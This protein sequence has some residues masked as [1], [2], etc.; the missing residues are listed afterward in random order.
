[1]S[2]EE[3]LQ[4]DERINNALDYVADPN[5]KT[6]VQLRTA[7]AKLETAQD[8]IKF[9]DRMDEEDK[10][11]ASIMTDYKPL[12][13]TSYHKPDEVSLHNPEQAVDYVYNTLNGGLYSDEETIFENEFMEVMMMLPEEKDVFTSLYNAGKK[14]EAWAFYQALQPY[15]NQ[16]YHYMED[17]REN[18]NA[19]RYPVMMSTVSAAATVAQPLEYIA[20]LPGRLEALITGNENAQTDPYSEM[21]SLT[22]LKTNIRNQVSSDLEDWGWVYN[23]FM[24]SVDSWLN[25]AVARGIGL[26]KEM[27]QAGTLGL[28]YTQAFE[29]SL[30]NTM[31]QGNDPFGYDYVEAFV[32]AMIETATEILSV[33]N[34]LADPTNLLTYVTKIA[35]SE[36]SE[37][38]VGAIIEPYIKEMIGHKNQYHERAKQILADGYYI[39]AQGNKVEV[40]DMDKATRQ[41]MREWNHDIRMAAQEALVSV[42]PSIGVGAMRMTYNNSQL[43][44]AIN[45]NNVNNET[46]ATRNFAEAASKLK[47]KQSVKGAQKVLDQLEKKGKAKNTTVGQLAQDVLRESGEQLDE[48]T[49]ESRREQIKKDLMDAGVEE[50]EA[51]AFADSIEQA[52]EKGGLDKIGKKQRDAING[53]Q[54]AANTLIN[55]QQ[56]FKKTAE[57][58]DQAYGNEKD[59]VNARSV[60]MNLMANQNTKA[61]LY[62]GRNV[63]DTKEYSEA[64]GEE[65]KGNRGVIVYG[66]EGSKHAKLLRITN[67]TNEDGQHLYEVEV[68]GK[69]QLVTSDQIGTKNLGTAAI[70]E[71]QANNPRF[72]S[73][74]YVNKLLQEV[75]LNNKINPGVLM[76]DAMVIRL[77]AFT[78]QEMPK[79][80]LPAEVAQRMYDFSS[81][82]HRLNRENQTKLAKQNARKAGQGIARFKG[83]DI[84]TEEFDKAIE[85]LSEADKE[86]IRTYGALAVQAGFEV[87]FIDLDDIENSTDRDLSEFK[88][89]GNELYGSESRK[90]IKL[91]IA[92]SNFTMNPE[93]GR[94]IPVE[95]E[96]HHIGIAFGHE[97]VHWLQRNT[98]DGYDNLA[99]YVLAEQ[100]KVLGTAGL[101]QQIERY[102]RN[103][104]L[105][106]EDAISELVADSCDRIFNQKEVIDHIQQTNVKLYNQL[107]SFVKDLVQRAKKVIRGHEKSMSDAGRRMSEQAM[108]K[109]AELYNIAWDEATGRKT[110]SGTN[111]RKSKFNIDNIKNEEYNENNEEKEGINDEERRK[112]S[113]ERI[114]EQ[115][116]ELLGLGRNW[117]LS[118]KEALR[119]LKGNNQGII[120]PGQK[121]Y[122]LFRQALI[123]SVFVDRK[124][125]PLIWL[126][127]TDQQ[128]SVFDI[129]ELINTDK[130]TGSFFTDNPDVAN[131]YAKENVNNKHIYPAGVNS[132]HNIILNAADFRNDIIKHQKALGLIQYIHEFAK[133]Y[134]ISEDIFNYLP[135]DIYNRYKNLFGR[136]MAYKVFSYFDE[137]GDIDTVEIEKA[138]WDDNHTPNNQLIVFDKERIIPASKKFWEENANEI[139]NNSRRFSKA[140]LDDQ[141]MQAVKNHDEQLQQELI[142]QAAARAEFVTDEY[143]YHGTPGFGFTVW[144]MDDSQN[145]IF[146]SY[147]DK[148][149]ATYTHMGELR[150]IGKKYQNMG[151]D[152]MNVNDLAKELEEF[153]RSYNPVVQYTDIEGSKGYTA[154]EFADVVSDYVEGIKELAKGKTF[155]QELSRDLDKLYA[156]AHTG[157]K[158]E[159][160]TQ[161]RSITD[162]TGRFDYA[163]EDEIKD[164]LRNMGAFMIDALA[165]GEDVVELDKGG[166]KYYITRS[167]FIR[168]IDNLQNDKEGIYKLYTRPGEQWVIDAKGANWN[169]IKIDD[170]EMSHYFYGDEDHN[171]FTT[172]EIADYVKAKHPYLTS[173]RINNVYDHGGRQYSE[174]RQ[175]GYGD[176]AIFF[177]QNDVKSADPVTYDDNGN[178][179]KPSERFNDEKKDIRWSRA[180]NVDETR[181][182]IAYHNLTA[183]QLFATLRLGGFPMPSIG[184]T[185][186]NYVNDRYGDIS[187]VFYKDTIDPKQNRLNKVYGGDAWTPTYPNVEYKLSERKMNAILKKIN[188]LIPQEQQLDKVYLYSENITKD[189][190]GARGDVVQAVKRYDILKQAYL[191][192]K[193]IST[194]M[195]MREKSLASSTFKN[196]QV[197][198]VVEA[199]GE[200]VIREAYEN[201]YE[202][203]EKHPEIEQT[204]MDTLNDMRREELEKK[205]DDKEKVN[206]MMAAIRYTNENFG[207]GK[208]QQMLLGAYRYIN[209]GI[210]QEVDEYA[211]KDL[212]N[213]K[214]DEADYEKWLAD[215]FD[216][217]IEKKGIRN[218]K[219]Y[220]TDSGNA[221][222]WE[223]LHDEENLENVVR[224]MKAEN[225]KGANAFFNQSAILALGTK[226]FKSLD[227]IR[228]NKGQ[229]KHISDEEMSAAKKDIVNRFG[230]LTDE[231]T[232]VK[233]GNL[234]DVMTARDRVRDAIVYAVT[235][236]RTVDG[237]KRYMGEYNYR[238]TNEQAQEIADLMV[239]I[240]NLPTEYFEAKPQRGVGLD[241]IATVLVPEGTSEELLDA[242]TEQGISYE[243]YDGTTEDRLAKM[244]AMDDVKFSRFTPDSM[245]VQTWMQ[246]ATYSTFQTEDERALWET[247]MRMRSS[248][249]LS[250]KKQL[251]YQAKIK[252]MEGKEDQLTPTQ[253]DDLRALRNKLEIEKGKYERMQD[254]MFRITTG[255]GFASMMYRNNMVLK[256]YIQGK[257]QDQVRQAVEDMLKLVQQTQEQIQ[258]DREELKSL[259]QSQAV[260]TMKSY[261]G[262]SSLS[263]MATNLRKAY[264]S[265]LSKGEI[266]NRLAE[267][268]LKQASG[269][270]ITADTEALARDLLD[271]IRGLQNDLLDY[272]HG[273]KLNIGENLL[274]EYI[275][276]NRA[277]EEVKRG[278]N[279]TDETVMKKA[280]RIAL[281]QINDSIKGS[282][283]KVIAQGKSR[284]SEQWT[285]LRGYNGALVDISE[286]GS[287]I[288][289]LYA[290]LDQIQ[291]NVEKSIADSK[292]QFDFDDVATMVR[293]CVGNVT[294][295]LSGDAAA[296]AQINNL[297]KQIAELSKKTEKTADNMEALNR[298]LDDVLLAGQKAKGWTTILQRDVADAIRYYNKTAKVAAQVEKNEVRKK[299]IET[300][301]S[302]HTKDLIEQ[303]NRFNEKLKNDKKARELAQD[304]NV[305]R[306]KISTVA[307]RMANRI[308]AETDQK[309]VPEETKPL[310]RKVLDMIS[311]YDANN[312]EESFFRKVTTWDKQNIENV[313]ER[314]MKLIARFGSFN[315]DSDLD[316]LIIKTPNEADNDYTIYDR[317]V[318]DLMDIESGLL[319]YR[320]AE[321]RG[322]VTLQDRKN[323]L[324]KVQKAISQI[325]DI[326]KA[327]SEAD[328]AGR[329]WQVYELAEMMRD[330]L[331]N[332]TFKGERTGFGSRARTKASAAVN[333][334]N[335]TPEYFFRRLKNRTMS[336][337]H[338]G[339]KD[340]ENRSGLEALRARARIAQIAKDT[341][342]STW[343][344]QEK[345]EVDVAGGRTITMT[346]EQIMTLY[347][348]WKREHNQLRPED[349]AHLLK[350]GF[351]LAQNEQNKGKPGRVKD[352]TRPV[353]M[354]WNQLQKL[355]GYLTDQQK[356]Y[357]DAI[358]EYMSGELAEIGNEA[359]MRMYGIKKFTEQYYFPIKSWGGVLNSRSDAGVNSNNE[360]RAAQWSASKRVKANASNAIEIS[361]FTPTAMKHVVGMITY[362]TVAPAIENMNKVLNQ[363]LQYG[364]VKYTPDGEV[365]EDDS[366]R[367][368]MRAAFKREYG[369]QAANYLQKFMKDMNGGVTTERTAFDM[370]LGVFKKNAV[371]G[372]LSVAAQQPLSYIRAAM[373]INPKYLAEALSPKY[374]KGSYAEM[375]EH[376]GV[377]VIKEMGKFDMNFGQT[378]QEWITPEGMTTKGQRIRNGVENVL[379]SGPQ[380]MDA[381]TWTRMW[382]AVKLEQ[383]AQ[384]KGMDYKSEEFM[385]L[386]AERFNELMR[387]TQ[388][389]DSVMTKSQNMRSTSWYAK[390][391]TSFMAEPTLSLN[392]LEDAWANRKEQG[393][394]KNVA[395][396]IA[397]FL[398]S[399]AAQAGAKGLFGTGRS[400]KKKRN[401]EETFLNKFWYNFL[402]EVNILGLIPGYRQ[403]IDVLTDGEINDD[404]IG[405][406]GK[407]VEVFDNVYKLMTG[408][409]KST[410]RM[411]EDSV[412]QLLQL[413]TNV[414]AKNLM[415]DFRAMVNFFSDGQAEWLTGDTY[416]QRPTNSSVLKYDWINTLMSEDMIGMIN[417][418]LGE[419]GYGTTATDYYKRIY[420]AEKAGNKKAAEEMRE[421]V[422]TTSAAEDPEKSLNT[423]LREYAK[424]DETL[425]SEEKLNMQKEYGLAKTGSYVLEEYEKGNLSREDAERLYRQE[426]PKAKDKDV[427]AALDKVDYEKET[428]TEIGNGYSNYTRMYDAMDSGNDAEYKKATE[429]LKKNGYEE[430]DIQDQTKAHITKLYKDGEI[431]RDKAEQMLKKYRADLGADDIWWTLDRIEYGKATGKD[432]GSGQYYRLYDAISNNRSD[433]IK[434][435][436]QT[437]TKHGVKKE[438]I[439]KQLSSQYRE[440]YLNATGEEKTRLKDALTKAYKAIGLTAD[441]ALKIIN[442]WKKTDKKK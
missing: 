202:Y 237:I 58:I 359:S 350:G 363:Q 321:G 333:Y 368:N 192:D 352:E 25:V 157:M 187:V 348:T 378:M 428:G 309:N 226:N 280:R 360:N 106:L 75:E 96:T 314:L 344:G 27:W 26:P 276:N 315:A 342:F 105:D 282:G 285:E 28:F 33:E 108:K 121:G 186:D 2:E 147:S 288:N 183:D 330:D 177:N 18:S 30:Q 325:W 442:G 123:D 22:R 195:P 181:D 151:L 82:E 257:T 407:A 228:K 191:A 135:G 206:K 43:G 172:R 185:R 38:I 5:G 419:A 94:A 347:A 178:V 209:Q 312:E 294:T 346:T 411:L 15:L 129:K 163:N 98:L 3:K 113:A 90:G 10:K 193:G 107:R 429:Y 302:Q 281:K 393:G 322:N 409:G 421:Y 432:A 176:I 313:R 250:L 293:A 168:Q 130:P 235:K 318:Q 64:E 345:H 159:A 9:L 266:E 167:A 332:S 371:F 243:V 166:W 278:K 48:A 286:K 68:D 398:L 391:F 29:T 155:E 197:L 37:E 387:R 253:K 295:Y 397:T 56:Q 440:K 6:G 406:I 353:R 242:L 101:N 1:M 93:T 372:S 241:E 362:N 436:V 137:Y 7:E 88:G 290:A 255:E 161:L 112:S 433:E 117:D 381:M 222:S 199:L 144:N 249:S 188:Q 76:R 354:T 356:A 396:A 324:E 110:E 343:D 310:V 162:K 179:I 275:S 57:A 425:S 229:L 435:A 32:D 438:N 40:K 97:S 244:R 139:E 358:V 196:D 31:S 132:Q 246:G 208:A 327:R 182:L 115:V 373:M 383:M 60:A 305:L 116:N 207:F 384:H 221:R 233:D 213:S 65:V 252:E 420:E 171:T 413:T 36:P 140:Q 201:G 200:D 437:M 304:N 61:A 220:Y 111:A 319:E 83:F 149:A 16:A 283:V 24:S 270:D 154:N 73:V 329:K 42:G 184:I 410:Y 338:T 174:N 142:A 122:E 427:L 17:L 365:D 424:K 307:T 418:R 118:G 51:G 156:L 66:E 404:A 8:K 72:Y 296:R 392:V 141:Y 400:P 231:L 41:A 272:L 210:Q 84:G 13:D 248:M 382:T 131:I 380:K 214:L 74:G 370:L 385:N 190:N 189:V 357:V 164:R 50:T 77:N 245:D 55:Y 376:S 234:Y 277:T 103:Q 53:N 430:K 219:D 379:T 390:T 236:A 303:Q 46:D 415:R 62:T 258:K 265:T 299:L 79:T 99:R 279:D 19:R 148:L 78:E 389:Y 180:G 254:D 165:S 173:I 320:N 127:G 394:K 92:G 402:S 260:Q 120:R 143:G 59:A 326:V 395:K 204:I 349:T 63:V 240:G 336:L 223:A 225:D 399:A 194:E 49:K 44:R 227:D 274:D 89:K 11:Y 268:V 21:Y 263:Q 284:F 70:I 271:K 341:G 401:K 126:H 417:K 91:N 317:V 160:R 306:R 217:V 301:K 388:V 308:F 259:A 269:Q 292:K 14:N 125:N 124:K 69:K 423:K 340:A 374:W 145:E 170:P 251:D 412:G 47:G 34:K 203:Y 262:K 256:D 158:L 205:I 287:E 153:Y 386:V 23:G 297:M 238:L 104:G 377:A 39:D 169:R 216:G 337:L 403:M 102:M 133:Q 426:N 119:L 215:L 334:G 289:G 405:M 198:R 232:T 311:L 71:A 95:N 45:S 152:I 291:D 355:G 414:P 375:M 261:M 230:E 416:E 273:V 364:E 218:N 431:S 86:L 87:D 300:L 224:V 361:D 146:V 328:I 316:F 81:A 12:E 331:Q 351:V 264:G 136:E 67:Q 298:Q 367:M 175:A 211:L 247:Y 150:K 35:I 134:H 85:N 109:V 439:K 128:F 441:E 339:L 369:Q 52:L 422:I 212:I 335:L 434:N 138:I 4:F 80:E 100:R 323:A 20:N 54:A 114:R 267:M 366:Y 239:E 408:E